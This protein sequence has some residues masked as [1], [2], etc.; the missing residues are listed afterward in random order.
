MH[1]KL[2]NIFQ[3]I[4]H[5]GA[6]WRHNSQATLDHSKDLSFMLYSEFPRLFTLQIEKL[7][8]IL[9]ACTQIVDAK[10]P[11]PIR[12]YILVEGQAWKGGWEM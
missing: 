8:S 3:A 12:V 4:Y 2:S 6:V 10:W 1:F 9:S 7:W 11:D 5:V